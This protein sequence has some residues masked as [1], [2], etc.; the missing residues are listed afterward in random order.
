MYYSKEVHHISFKFSQYKD[1]DGALLWRLIEF[2]GN[3]VTMATQYSP[4]NRKL[5]LRG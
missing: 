2:S 5:F 4:W 1:I 3:A